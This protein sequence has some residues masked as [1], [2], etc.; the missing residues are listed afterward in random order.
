MYLLFQFNYG[1]F[2]YTQIDQRSAN[3]EKGLDAKY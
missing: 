2:G 1:Y 3:Y